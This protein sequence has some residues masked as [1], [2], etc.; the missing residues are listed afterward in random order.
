MI[1]IHYY[2]LNIHMYNM[3]VPSSLHYCVRI[4][5]GSG[6]EEIVNIMSIQFCLSILPEREAPLK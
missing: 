2:T 6:N 5:L 3:C 1:E 4:R